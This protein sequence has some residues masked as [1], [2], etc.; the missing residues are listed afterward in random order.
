MQLHTIQTKI[1]EIRGVKVMLDFDLAKLYQ[2]PTKSLNLA[3]KRHLQRFP[4]DFMF[5]LSKHEWDALRFQIETLKKGRGKFSKYV[6]YVFTEQGLAMLSGILNSEIAVEVNISIMRTFVMLRQ[7]ASTNKELAEKLK[8]LEAKYDQQFNN[9]AQALDYL[10][11]KDQQQSDQQN[12]KKI[13]Y[14]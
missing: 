8:E 10:I 5:K 2:V 12:R 3:V 7:L 6:P 13:G 9:V 1:H 14:K 4:E 11:K